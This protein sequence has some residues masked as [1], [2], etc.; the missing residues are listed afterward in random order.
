M[1]S[2]HCY[3]HIKCSDWTIVEFWKQNSYAEVLWSWKE[4]IHYIVFLLTKMQVK[5]YICLCCIYT[6]LQN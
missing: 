5:F 6:N 4:I 3:Q 1:Q 2:E